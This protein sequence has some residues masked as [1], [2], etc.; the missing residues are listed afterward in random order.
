MESLVS[1]EKLYSMI[2]YH[3]FL[4]LI[5]FIILW[6]LFKIKK[7]VIKARKYKEAAEYSFIA[8]LVGVSLIS[9]SLQIYNHNVFFF[10][11]FLLLYYFFIPIFFL[12]SS[13]YYRRN[14]RLEEYKVAKNIYL[15]SLFLV[16]IL[17]VTF[18]YYMKGVNSF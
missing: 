11:L 8:G 17:L 12:S 1:F 14:N 2:S 15:I 6:I 10:E 4:Q 13:F 5:I 7:Q 18:K 16:I 3:F 9:I